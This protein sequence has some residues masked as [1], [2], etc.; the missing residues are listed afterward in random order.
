[1]GLIPLYIIST[2]DPLGGFLV[3]ILNPIL[4]PLIGHQV[5]IVITKQ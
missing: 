5:M 3:L 4:P 2:G 1:M